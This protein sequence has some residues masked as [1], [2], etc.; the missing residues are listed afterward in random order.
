M[1]NTLQKGVVRH[2]VFKEDGIWYA[3]GL[4][5]NIV[6]SGSTPQEAFFLLLQ[7]MRGY[8]EAARKV[9][10]RPNILNQRSDPEYEALWA[11]LDS[12]EQDEDLPYPVFQFGR[13]NV[14]DRRG[15]LAA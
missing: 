7:A 5:F 1:Q 6:E 9:K 4:E 14:T 15:Y 3:V 2:I 10:T 11:Q 13:T 8:V 12:G